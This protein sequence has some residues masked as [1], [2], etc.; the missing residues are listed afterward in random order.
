MDKSFKCSVCKNI[1]VPDEGTAGYGVK[2]NGHKICYPCCATRDSADMI[3]TGRA[4]LYLVNR[5]GRQYITNWPGSLSI[6]PVYVRK[7]KHNIAGTRYDAWFTFDNQ[8]WH[9]VNYGEM[10]QIIHCRRLKQ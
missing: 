10:T 3:K 5:D 4:C 1:V 8:K 2:G 6:G 7:G 9:G